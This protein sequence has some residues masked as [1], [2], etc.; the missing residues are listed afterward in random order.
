M[1]K[2]LFALTIILGALLSSN[3]SNAQFGVELNYGMNGSYEPSYSG[4][5]H[6]GGGVSYDFNETFGAKIDFASDK[7][8]I[9]NDFG[10]ET[11]TSNT[12]ISLQGVVNVS[13]L[14][15]DR[16]FYN[17][18]VVLAHGG[19]GLSILKSDINTT[20]TDHILN[21][22]IGVNPQ[23]KVAEGLYLGIDASFIANI[24]QHYNFDGTSTYPG[25]DANSIT[26][27]M[28]NLSATISYKFGEY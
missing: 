4:F 1:K 25:D 6:F 10:T 20:G 16:S 11:G 2:N 19:A 17:N 27:L 8:S 15:D 13:N 14:I 7:F 28:Y 21:V 22:I 12:R 24:S 5:T 26:G 3:I 9:K 23:Y 18:F